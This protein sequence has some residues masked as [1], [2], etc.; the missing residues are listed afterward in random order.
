MIGLTVTEATVGDQPDEWARGSVSRA[1]SLGLVPQTF[2]SNYV[3]DTT[4]AEYCAL[5]VLLYEKATGKQI[6]SRVTF[7]DTQDINVAKMAS[8]GVV[9]G[10]GGNKFDPNQNL[11]REQAATMMARLA[12]VMGRPLPKVG[13][14]FADNKNISD[15]AIE[16]VGQMLQS[17][18]MIGTGVNEFSPKQPYTREQSI[19]TMLRLYDM[20]PAQTLLVTSN[21]VAIR[22][23]AVSGASSL[24]MAHVGNTFLMLSKTL[25]NS[26]Y[27]VSYNGR[28]AYINSSY[29]RPI[30]S[31]AMGI[32]KFIRIRATSMTVRAKP[33]PNAT[34]AGTLTSG[35]IV[36]LA[37][38]KS[39]KHTANAEFFQPTHNKFRH[40]HL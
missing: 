3:Q 22:S 40:F 34:K 19:I 20:S 6:E 13:A 12:V 11:T 39:Y 28:I 9:L 7:A 35:N 14:T 32:G 37:D 10:V 36:E 5:S 2:Q 38:L 1:I 21:T 24:G 16:A 15:W 23:G 4:R 25:D 30:V 8:L 31:G 26:Y 17:G 18:I 33:E 29:A 27:K